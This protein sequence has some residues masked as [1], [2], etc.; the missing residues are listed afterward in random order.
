MPASVT[1]NKCKNSWWVYLIQTTAGS[2]YA[3]ITTNPYRRWRQHCGDLRGGAKYLKAFLPQRFVYLA[4]YPD[5]AGAASREV[6]LKQ[7]AHLEKEKM[8]QQAWGPTQKYLRF[9]QLDKLMRDCP[10][11]GN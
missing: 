4:P 5:H 11:P 10:R 2:F 8:I 3:G 7:M 6:Q 9:W 1:N